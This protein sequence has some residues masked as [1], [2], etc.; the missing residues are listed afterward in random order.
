MDGGR[1]YQIL[2]IGG[3]LEPA[4]ARKIEKSAKSPFCDFLRIFDLLFF[5]P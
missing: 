2:K 3:D 5:F 1:V 4:T